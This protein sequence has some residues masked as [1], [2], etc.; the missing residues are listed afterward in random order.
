MFT[1]RL[2]ENDRDKEFFIS[3]PKKLYNKKY[4]TQNVKTERKILNNEHPLSIDFDIYPFIVL[5]EDE[6][7]LSRSILTVYPND[8]I[9]YVGYFE[10]VDN[11]DSVSCLF[12]VIKKKAIE[13]GLVKLVGPVDCSIW[14]KYRFK[15]DNFDNYYT[16]EPY[17]LEY[18]KELW[19]KVGFIVSDNYFSNQLRVPTDEDTIERYQKAFRIM[20]KR[21]IELRNPTIETFDF[22]IKEIYSILINLY[23]GFQ[24]FKYITSTQF[25]M[26]FEDLKKVLRMDMV[27]VAY[28][29]NE[30][31]GF[32][33][34]VPNYGT[35]LNNLSM[36]NMVKLLE[37]KRNPKEYVMLYLGANSRGM[38]LGSVFAEIG[39]QKMQK[40]NCTSITALIHEG[41]ESGRLYENLRTNKYNYVLM[42][43]DL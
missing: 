20:E 36:W 26:L 32:F 1:C 25:S 10:S 21:N 22:Y 19:E 27:Y 15:I 23:S 14:I 41:N 17:N 8:N 42:S 39:K 24:G 3:L 12:E 28:R 43:L 7:I 16:G 35:I 30:I 13:L 18:Y 38:G 33:V 9:G 40:Y 29:D 5:D 11:I 6:Q 37:Y 31:V 4:L 2:V 34:M